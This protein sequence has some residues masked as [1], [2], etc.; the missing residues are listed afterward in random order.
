MPSLDTAARA[1]QDSAVRWSTGDAAAYDVVNDAC[2]ALAAG[3]DSPTLRMLAACSRLEAG[4]DAPALFPQAL[5]EL[6]LTFY[7]RGSR[8][9]KEAALR[10]LASLLLTGD[11]TP[12][13][14]A[15]E[16]HRRFG[17]AL[18]LADRL[19]ALHDEYGI[20]DY[21][22][23]TEAQVS[24]DITTEARHLTLAGS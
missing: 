17:H 19:S 15:L 11:L 10:T 4:Y 20:L 12:R 3:L 13:E 8:A 23:K 24:A 2:E 18:P 9:G 5:H 14:L 7:P 22:D 21:I 1:L 6:G 16:V